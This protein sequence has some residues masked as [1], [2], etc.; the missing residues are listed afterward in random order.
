MMNEERDN[1]LFHVETTVAEDAIPLCPSCLEPCDPMTHYCPNCAS[2]ETIN[3]L[4]SY[5]PFV[6]LR[7][8]VGMLGKLWRKTWSQDTSWIDG[9]I[10]FLMFMLF[11]PLLLVFGL[12]VLVFEKFKSPRKQSLIQ[13]ENE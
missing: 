9:A 4:A 12:P 8:R 5:M 11:C 1:H 2:N 7:F 3:P 13:Q 10:Y 6:D